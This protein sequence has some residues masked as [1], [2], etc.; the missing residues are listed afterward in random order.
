[1][2]DNELVKKAQS[3]DSEALNAIVDRYYQRVLARV[4]KVVPEQDV[5]DVTHDIFCR[6]IA[7]LDNFAFRGEFSSWLFAIVRYQVGNYFRYQSYRRH[8]SLESLPPG[9]AS[10]SMHVETDVAVDDI[11][12]ALPPHYRDLLVMRHL[13]GMSFSEIAQRSGEAYTCVQSRY[14]R[15]LK[16]ARKLAAG[17]DR[18]V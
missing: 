15:A 12:S 3:G 6:A 4:H 18:S 16:C 7:S 5:R 17:A 9:A 11:L 8:A 2:S 13:H 10:Y 14:R 1:M